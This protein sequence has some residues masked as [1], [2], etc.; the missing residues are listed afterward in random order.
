MFIT[1]KNKLAYTNNVITFVAKLKTKNMAKKKKST[2][3]FPR[4]INGITVT[5]NL[6]YALALKW[7]TDHRT[8]LSWIE[9]GDA[10]ITHPESLS[11]IN[12]K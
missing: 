10:M 5:K 6:L 12:A 3:K 1:H 2:K 11:I 9:K 4:V 7:D 8:I